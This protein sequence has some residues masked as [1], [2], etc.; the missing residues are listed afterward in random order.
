MLEYISSLCH[1]LT[2]VVGRLF[3]FGMGIRHYKMWVP[4]GVGGQKVGW[5]PDPADATSQG[6]EA[7]TS[8]L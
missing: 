6:A 5:F 4:L 8:R 1:T 2:H 3:P 7:W